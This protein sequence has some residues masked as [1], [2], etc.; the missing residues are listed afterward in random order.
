MARGESVSKSAQDSPIWP[1]SRRCHRVREAAQCGTSRRRTYKSRAL[2]E[3]AAAMHI[4]GASNRQIGKV[5]GVKPH[6]V[7]HM[8]ADS[9]VL[10]EYRR[11]LFKFVPKALENLDLLLTPGQG[12]TVEELGRNTRWLLE[13]AQVAVFK[14]EVETKDRSPLDDLSREQLIG[15]LKAKIARLSGTLRGQRPGGLDRECE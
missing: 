2:I 15:L 8:L 14:Q 7:P 6:T 13:G 1:K 11:E 4:E 10:K 12:Q 9:E 5:L 3:R